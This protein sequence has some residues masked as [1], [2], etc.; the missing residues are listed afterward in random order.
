[1]PNATDGKRTK[2]VKDDLAKEIWRNPNFK[3]FM[4][5]TTAKRSNA[6]K[7]EDVQLAFLAYQAASKII[8]SDA[9]QTEWER[10]VDALTVRYAGLKFMEEPAG[11]PVFS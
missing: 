9:D 6:N 3:K 5:A 10:R 8:W 1:M 4:A 7:I 11:P 2:S